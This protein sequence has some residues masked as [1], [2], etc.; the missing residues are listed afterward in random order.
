MVQ[1][2]DN[3]RPAV[4]MLAKH[5]FWLVALLVPV[6]V[7]PVLAA[8]NSGLTGRIA[9]RRSEIESKLAQVRRVSQISP[10]PNEKWSEA[11][12]ADRQVLQKELMEEWKRLWE[13]Q[14]QIRVWPEEL[15]PEFVRRVQSLRPGGQLDR[16]ALINYQRRVPRFVQSLPSRMGAEEFMAPEEMARDGVGGGGPRPGGFGARPDGG[17]VARGPRPPIAWNPADQQMLYESF[18]WDKPP[19]TVQVLM[20]QEELWLYGVLCDILKECNADAT[21]AHDSAVAY[22]EELAVGYRAAED[23]PGG[24]GRIYVPPSARPAAGDD[25]DGMGMGMGGAG[26]G[27]MP[28]EFGME[29]GRTVGRPPHPRFSSSGGPESAMAMGREPGDVRSFGSPDDEFLNWAYVDFSGKPLMAEELATAPGA[30]MLRLSPF[31]LR[32]VVDQRKLDMLLTKLATSPIPIVVR[33]V[34][35][36]PDAVTLDDGMDGGRG[37]GGGRGGMGGGRGGMGGGRG[38]M[39]GGRG[40]MGGGRGG[41][42]GVGMTAATAR[43]HDVT[44]EILG[45]V[46]LATPPGSKLP[47]ARRE[48]DFGMRIP[49]LRPRRPL[50]ASRRSVVVAEFVRRRAVAGDAS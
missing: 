39:G 12:E 26:I 8:G 20:A 48:D 34:R 1:I 33:Q 25:F 21:G 7:L 18:L 43:P 13:S 27:M 17:G 10:H 42:G 2:P 11:I 5:H 6:I 15:G 37:M 16:P 28:N 38:G 32:V 47:A 23:K 14:R 45:T 30:A 46:A 24:E 9:A 36:N 3:I 40:G 50:L 41:M 22:V 49:S 44:V 31:L 29:D 4:A 35:I 19:S